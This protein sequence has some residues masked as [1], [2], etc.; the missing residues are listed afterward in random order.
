MNNK[1]PKMSESSKLKH[2]YSLTSLSTRFL[3]GNSLHNGH[4][5]AHHPPPHHVTSSSSGGLGLSNGNQQHNHHHQNHHHQSMLMPPG[6]N[7]NNA[8]V[9]K[10]SLDNMEGGSDG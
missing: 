3:N 1:Y 2:S 10:D 6:N 9:T 5:T 7:N 8:H 4:H